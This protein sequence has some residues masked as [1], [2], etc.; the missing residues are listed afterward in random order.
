MS[1]GERVELNR[2]AVAEVG[3][4]PGDWGVEKAPSRM[5]VTR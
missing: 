5:G 1:I 2:T 3:R 4:K